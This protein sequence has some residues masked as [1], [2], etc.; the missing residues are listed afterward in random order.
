VK[1]INV[2]SS[3]LRE[4]EYENSQYR[5]VSEETNQTLDSHKFKKI[6]VPEATPEEDD[7]D[8]NNSGPPEI[9]YYTGGF[10]L[11]NGKWR[12]EAFNFTFT[13]K[14]RPNFM[15][16]LGGFYKHTVEKTNWRAKSIQKAN[17]VVNSNYEAAAAAAAAS[18]QAKQQSKKKN[19]KETKDSKRSQDVSFEEENFSPKKTERKLDMTIPRDFVE[20]F[21]DSI[22]HLVG[23]IEFN[24]DD[25]V[26]HPDDI[27]DGVERKFKR[28]NLEIEKMCIHGYDFIVNGKDL[29]H[30]NQILVHGK[31]VT[32]MILTPIVPP[33][34]EVVDEIE[35][36]M[37][38]EGSGDE[39]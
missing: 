37:D 32:K 34:K 21:E 6:P 4:D 28:D 31:D 24:C 7:D 5:L 25:E 38:G 17:D 39:E 26:F 9:I 11:E 1:A 19:K 30:P 16:E 2:K 20:A 22:P 8:Q 3:F 27:Q 23:P 15:E 14:T 18:K 33:E 10:F 29:R 35:E 12:Y 13:N 36:G